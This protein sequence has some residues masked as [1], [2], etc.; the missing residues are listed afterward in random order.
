MPPVV[1][2]VALGRLATGG[3]PL[4]RV[5]SVEESMRHTRV[6]RRALLLVGIAI[7]LGCG[8]SATGTEGGPPP[9]PPP[10]PPPSNS[11]SVTNNTF[12]PG[13]LTVNVGSTVT[14]NWN[15]CSG[16]DGYGTGE[17]CVPHSV[18]LDDGSASSSTQS[19]GSFSHQFTT[20]G[21]YA[22]HCAVHGA[23]MSGRIVVL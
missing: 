23:A 13:N 4:R 20:A 7:A 21:T 5:H 12:T 11:V 15:T 6:G 19:T 10:P 18:V 14:W 1:A 16:G 3:R 9:P 8:G 17:T 22:Y 2:H